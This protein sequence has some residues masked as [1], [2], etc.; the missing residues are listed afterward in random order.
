MAYSAHV[1]YRDTH[2]LIPTV[3]SDESVLETLDLP[4]QVIVSLTE[5]DAA[6]FRRSLGRKTLLLIGSVGTAIC[7][8]GV[9]AIFYKQQHREY[10]VWLLVGYIFFFAVSQGVV[11]W[12]Y[13]S[14][15]FPTRVRS[16]GQSLGSG[17]Q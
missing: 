9:A 5:L 2:R 17:S 1:E 3:C 8:S 11:I 15:V 10:L 14:E 4:A 16:K 13:I 6:V 12:V 7:L